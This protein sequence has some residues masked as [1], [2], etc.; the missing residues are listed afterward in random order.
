MLQL[1]AD[2]H[3]V[4]LLFTPAGNVTERSVRLL[5]GDHSQEGIVEIAYNGRWGML[6]DNSFSTADAQSICQGLG[7]DRSDASTM[8]LSSVRYRSS[9]IIMCVYL[10]YILF[11]VKS[12][13]VRA[14]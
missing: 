11:V 10:I 1:Y 3:Y 13:R 8:S 9:S 14:I 6:C 12:W 4:A 7:H 5:G 2:G